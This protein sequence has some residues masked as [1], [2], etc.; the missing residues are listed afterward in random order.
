MMSCPSDKILVINSPGG[1]LFSAVRLLEAISTANFRVTTLA[2]GHCASAAFLIFLAG[3]RRVVYEF[4]LL[5]SHQASLDQ[6]GGSVSLNDMVDSSRGFSYTNDIVRAAY[7]KLLSRNPRWV[8][9]HLL[10]DHDVYLSAE[11]ALALGVADEIQFHSCRRDVR[12]RIRC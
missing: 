7:C 2:A 3:H 12:P 8:T 4:S 10:N 11:Q 6:A 5:M 1:C 9:T